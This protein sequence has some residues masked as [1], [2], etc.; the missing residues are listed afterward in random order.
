MPLQHYPEIDLILSWILPPL[1]GKRILDVGC[2]QGGIGFLLRRLPGGDKAYIIGVDS[3]PPY[4]AFC[5]RF[6]IYDEI[7]T[8]DIKDYL[9]FHCQRPIDIV[10]A[11]EVLEHIDKRTGEWILNMLEE[12]TQELIIIT[13]PNGPDLRGEVGGV[14]TEAHISVWHASEFLYRG[15]R[16]RGI[17]CRWVRREHADRRWKVA[18]WWML[19]PIAMKFPKI[20]DTIIA[21]KVKDKGGLGRHDA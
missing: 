13:T 4:T 7:W 5:R 12:I 1:S 2:G 8:C 15:Y 14:P 10:I 20:A 11:A 9:Q 16:V 18:L 6:S 17:G 3:W 19:T 21:V